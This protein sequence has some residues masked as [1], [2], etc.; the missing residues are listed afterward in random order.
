MRD[1]RGVSQD[2]RRIL[3][4]PRNLKLSKEGNNSEDRKHHVGWWLESVQ[5]CGS[6]FQPWRCNLLFSFN[7]CQ[8]ECKCLISCILLN[9]TCSSNCN[10]GNLFCADP[11][12]VPTTH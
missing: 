7:A 11:E 10:L 5:E 3:T 2:I 6:C 4:C 12:F 9:F 8:S 1:P